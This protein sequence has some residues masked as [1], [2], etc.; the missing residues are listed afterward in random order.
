MSSP[1]APAASPTVYYKITEER[2]TVRWYAVPP[3]MTHLNQQ[4]VDVIDELLDTL[5]V[6]VGLIFDKQSTM[7]VAAD[8]GDDGLRDYASLKAFLARHVLGLD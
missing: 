7:P 4:V 2:G 5:G 1:S 8:L 6:D 3:F